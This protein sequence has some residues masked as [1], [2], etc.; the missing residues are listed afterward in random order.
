MN[1]THQIIPKLYT[2]NPLSSLYLDPKVL[3]PKTA[4]HRLRHDAEQLRFLLQLPAA[5]IPA[6]APQRK[7]LEHALRAYEAVL[8]Q[9]SDTADIFA[10]FTR[11]VRVVSANHA[12]TLA[13]CWA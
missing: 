13:V 10:Q 2:K 12:R 11:K 5:T 1:R 4:R 3:Y 8:S 7:V 9:L 6:D